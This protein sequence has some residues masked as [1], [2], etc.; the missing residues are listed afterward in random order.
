MR[1][2]YPGMFDVDES[3]EPEHCRAYHAATALPRWTHLEFYL[4]S[5]HQCAP[6]DPE[7][8]LPFLQ[9]FFMRNLSPAFRAS[10]ASVSTPR[11][12]LLLRA[13]PGEVFTVLREDSIA[14]RRSKRNKSPAP[15]AFSAKRLRKK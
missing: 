12:Y 9:D 5:K 6:Q 1:L 11:D 8:F 7:D 13:A 4:P 2:Y 14:T 15:G 3:L 10:F